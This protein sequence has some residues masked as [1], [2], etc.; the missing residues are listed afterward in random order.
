MT[1]CNQ[2]IKVFFP[3]CIPVLLNSR[4]D[5]ILAPLGPCLR[6]QVNKHGAMDSRVYLPDSV[7]K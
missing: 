7:L 6:M 4:C 5:G 2:F 1:F 3:I